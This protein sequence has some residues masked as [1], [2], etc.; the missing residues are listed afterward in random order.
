MHFSF[1]GVLLI[2]ETCSFRLLAILIMIQLFTALIT[3]VYLL[4]RWSLNFFLPNDKKRNVDYIENVSM[5][6]FEIKPVW[7]ILILFFFKIEEHDS[8]ND[9]QTFVFSLLTKNDLLFLD[10]CF[11][12]F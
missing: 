7:F 10:L 11:H 8:L 6:V 12:S 3:K 9:Q 5:C 2:Q 4:F 1:D